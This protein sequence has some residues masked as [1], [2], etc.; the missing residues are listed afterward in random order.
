MRWFMAAV[1][2]ERE[3]R[4]GVWMRRACFLLLRTKTEIVL[5]ALERWSAEVYF[6]GINSV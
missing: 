2:D 5:A 4:G 1:R 3:V 6:M